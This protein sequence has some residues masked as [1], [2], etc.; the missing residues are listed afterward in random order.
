[1]GDKSEVSLLRFGEGGQTRWENRAA[2]VLTLAFC[3]NIVLEEIRVELNRSEDMLDCWQ[4]T[5]HRGAT[6][7]VV[8]NIPLNYL[9]HKYLVFSGDRQCLEGL[10]GRL[11]EENLLS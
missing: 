4:C 2:L 11:L 10:N 9:I 7:V 6:R 5:S 1:M 8:R 3:E